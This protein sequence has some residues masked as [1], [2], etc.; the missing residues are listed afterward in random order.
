M[1]VYDS[2]ERYTCCYTIGGTPARAP[3][4]QHDRPF[5]SFKTIQFTF[6]ATP[7]AP[8]GACCWYSRVVHQQH[9]A[10]SVR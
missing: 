6:T 2:I 10:L 7:A 8:A 5:K 3:P 1:T 9:V 4:I